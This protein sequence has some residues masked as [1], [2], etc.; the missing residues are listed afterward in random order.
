MRVRGPT[1]GTAYQDGST[2]DG[3]LGCQRR[4]LGVRGDIAMIIA[5]CWAQLPAP[6]RASYVRQGRL[7]QGAVLT[8]LGAA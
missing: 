8:G 3:A 1:I 5:A 7:M 6:V 4:S 2:S